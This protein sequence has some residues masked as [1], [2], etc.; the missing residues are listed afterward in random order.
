MQRV[1]SILLLVLIAPSLVG[2][3]VSD[4]PLV[5]RLEGSTVLHQEIS[6]FGAYTIAVS[7]EVAETV[8]GEVWMTLYDAPEDTST[9]SVYSTYLSFLENAGYDILLSRQPG[10]TSSAFLSEVYERAP[11]ADNGNYAFSAPITNGNDSVAAYISARRGSGPESVY[12]SIAIAAGWRAYPQYKLDVVTLAS[13]T[14]TIQSLGGA[15]EEGSSSG[16]GEPDEDTREAGDDLAQVDA[17]GGSFFSSDWS[18]AVRAGM[19]GY[20]FLDPSIAGGLVVTD[21]G[22]VVSVQSDGF[23]NAYGPFGHVAWYPNPNFGVAAGFSLITS[24]E[25]VTADSVTYRSTARL[26]VLQLAALSRIIGSHFPTTVA[27]GFTGGLA[28]VNLSRSEEGGAEDRYFGV[29]DLLPAFGFTGELTI[30]L[31]SV[32]E[33]FGGIEYLFVPFSTLEMVN[34]GGTPYSRIYNEG[35]LG[36]LM[37]RVGLVAEF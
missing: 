5:G 21:D 16:A 14:A 15:R 13:N 23:K 7:A 22:G 19:A 4:N 2:E 10:E 3:E 29:E 35:N 6:R 12:V 20:L 36:G 28:L 32:V 24:D 27:F 17:R 8:E 11:F 1:V 25:D 9:Y 18:L 31:F 30:P 26:V 37:L 33:L 34:D